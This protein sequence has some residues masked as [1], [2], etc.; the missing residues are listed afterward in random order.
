MYYD[1]E[2]DLT[3]YDQASSAAQGWDT[4]QAAVIAHPIDT[5]TFFQLAQH[6]HVSQ[7]TADQWVYLTD[8]LPQS[9]QTDLPRWYA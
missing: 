8:T 1:N 3:L 4:S 9:M 7:R 2:K 5:R 6:R